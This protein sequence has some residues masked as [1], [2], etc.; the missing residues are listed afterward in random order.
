[1]LMVFKLKDKR[2]VP[3]GTILI[4]YVVTIKS[5]IMKKIILGSAIT[6][7]TF[8]A[9][10]QGNSGKNKKQKKSEA[11]IEMDDREDRKDRR[12]DR[13]DEMKDRR[14]DR[15]DKMKDRREDRYETRKNG[16]VN[17]NRTGKYSKNTPRKVGDAFRRDFPNAT[18]VSWTKNQGVWTASFDGSGLLGG[19]KT[20]SY[21]AN[22]E[23]VGQ[24]SGRSRTGIFNQR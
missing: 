19:N 18:N 12:E 4:Y 23:R 16:D 8:G 22:G 21:R 13:N 1:M 14:E 9:F 5:L 2:V 11:R 17:N 3:S 10:A 6:L 15:K 24:V 7:L 20:V